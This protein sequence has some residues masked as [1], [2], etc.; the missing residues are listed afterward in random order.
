MNKLSILLLLFLQSAFVTSVKAQEQ[1]LDEVVA[2]VEEG[3]ILRSELDRAVENIVAQFN[4]NGTQLPPKSVLDKQVLER[5]I[6]IELQLQKAD[7][8]GV[9]VSE[10]DVDAA[11]SQVAGKNNLNLQQ[12]QMAIENDGLS[13]ADFRN[14][15]HKELKTEKIRNGLANQNVTVSDHE[16][17][18]FLADNNL[19]ES[20]VRLGHILVSLDANADVETVKAAEQ[21]VAKIHSDLE[22]GETFSILA[23]KFSDGQKAL[24]GGD[25]GW[26]VA[27]ELPTLFSDQIKSM[28]IGE[29]TYPIRS[30]SGFHIIRLS[31]KRKQTTKMITQ[32][33]AKHIMI[34]NTEL[35]TPA[36]GMDVINEIANQI[37]EGE[38]FSKMA[39]EK[40]DDVSSA[41][42]GGDLGWF[43]LYDFGKNIADVLIELED[44]EIS[45]PFQT[46]SGW[47][48][49]QKIGQRE[50]D[51]SEDLKRAQA[52]QT[53]RSRK[54]TEEVDKWIRDIRAEAFVEIRL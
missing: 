45:S 44:G 3:V 6:I 10:A 2:V 28:A 41:P 43:Q 53:I 20:E 7:Q 52:E 34:E 33:N 18:L 15:M 8:A 1:L 38:E 31:D 19:T 39:E 26:R 14:D 16:I 32:Y 50:T 47:H 25:L 46:Q 5:L 12:M 9:R 29:Y 48:L 36:Q 21:K 30:G 27:N 37:Q 51:I 17:S 4:A 42:L 23:T 11:L 40:S 24:D 22:K 54:V 49:I 35:M 13:F